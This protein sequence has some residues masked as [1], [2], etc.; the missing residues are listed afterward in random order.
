M[1]RKE[2]RRDEDN[3]KSANKTRTNRHCIVETIRES[4][5]GN[6]RRSCGGTWGENHVKALTVSRTEVVVASEDILKQANRVR[7]H[8]HADTIG[9]PV[10]IVDTTRKP[11]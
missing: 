11:T 6:K 5:L 10:N 8:L 4:R 1:E 9:R 3:K 7:A 2:K